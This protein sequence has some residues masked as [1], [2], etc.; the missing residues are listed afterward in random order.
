LVAPPG[1]TAFPSEFV[2]R[3]LWV[4]MRPSSYGAL[5]DWVFGD[6]ARQGAAGRALRDEVG[7]E[8]QLSARAFKPRA[9]V[10]PK[11]M[12]DEELRA[13][14]VPALFLVGENDKT[15]DPVKAAARMRQAGPQVQVEVVPGAGHDITFVMGEALGRRVVE[16]IGEQVMTPEK[17]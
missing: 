13:I 9:M 6:L 5:N 7:E 12:K 15:C 8:I 4:F 2:R 3:F 17:A 11:V 14:S 1:I 10:L 16:F